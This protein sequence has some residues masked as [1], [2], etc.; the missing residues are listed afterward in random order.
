[1]WFKI[2]TNRLYFENKNADVA[3]SIEADLVFNR[4]LLRNDLISI[5]E[6][7]KHLIRVI[8]IAVY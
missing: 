4:K 6:H 5:E 3:D 8:F 2:D 1:M 7:T